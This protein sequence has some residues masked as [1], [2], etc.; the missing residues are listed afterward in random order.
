MAKGSIFLS[1]KS[2]LDGDVTAGDIIKG[3]TAYSKNV[4]E[5][6]IGS[7]E[8]SGNALTND[9][10]L[11]KTFYNVD[12]KAKQIG[13]LVLTGSAV[14]DDVVSGKTFYNVDTKSKQ[15]GT[16]VLSGI[17]Q[18][19]LVYTGQ[20][21]Y[22]TDAK[23]KRTGTMPVHGPWTSSIAP[24]KTVA[25]PAGYHNGA[26]YMTANTQGVP[27]G[28]TIKKGVLCA[29]SSISAGMLGG[30]IPLSVAVSFSMNGGGGL[31]YAPLV[32]NVGTVNIMQFSYDGTVVSLLDSCI[33]DLES[34]F[35]SFMGI[36]SIS[37]GSF[38]GSYGNPY[39]RVVKWLEIV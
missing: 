16:L 37:L 8:L 4:R 21:F 6:I 33:L 15:T 22:N 5:K 29:G 7:L 26:G 35:S 1:G 14:S 20:T 10:V 13:S 27:I 24:G 18:E 30:K 17:A 9:V 3:K 36:N 32:T 34:M 39:I 25:I 28:Y 11:G 38:A 19:S 23:V 2:L 12:A 31:Q